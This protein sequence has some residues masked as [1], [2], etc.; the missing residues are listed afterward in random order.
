MVRNDIEKAVA[1]ALAE[2]GADDVSFSIDYPPANQAG[3]YASNAALAAAKSLKRPPREVATEL[4]EKLA[5]ANIPFVE[6]IEAAG[7]GFLN[8][9]LSRD[10]FA[11]TVTDIRAAGERWGGNDLLKGQ[12]IIAEYT[13][14]NPFKEFHIGHL[15]SNAI[16]ESIARLLAASG[17]EVR[18]ANYQG[19]VGLHVAKAIWGIKQLGGKVESAKQ[20]GE[21]YAKGAA[22]Y[23][24]DEQA[25]LEINVINKQVYERSDAEINALYDAG[26]KLSLERFEELY[27]TLGTKFDFYFFE[28]E[29]GPKGKELV[30]ANKGKVFEESEGAVVYRGEQDGLHTRVFLNKEGLPTYEAKELAL[31]RMKYEKFAYDRSIVITANEVNEYFKVVLAA[32]KRIE[33]ELAQKTEHVGHGFMRLTMGKMSSRKGNV[34]TGESLLEDMVVASKEKMAER[35]PADKE[36]IASQV[37]VA[38]IKYAILR[39]TAGKDIV[40]DEEKSLSLEGDSGP[41]LQYAHTRGCSILRKAKEEG[42]EASDERPAKL[43]HPEK[44]LARFPEAV[45]RAASTY[46]PHH[47]AQYLTELAGVFNSW[48]AVERVLDGSPEAPYKLALV[49]AVRVT[50]KNGLS[51]LGC[52]APEEM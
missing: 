42:V 27:A 34:I 32:L 15:M 9:H 39:Q 18:R 50:L 38:G 52:Q 35:A 29:A 43:S 25:K 20:L 44:L 28:S 31:P 23:E 5:A 6:K 26:R 46:E 12:K 7:A 19:D 47:I 21:A 51:L 30:L 2:M 14:P 45:A 24:D 33:P 1:K 16:G 10:F 48:Y 11:K 22:A 36:K 8:F 13:D 17:A 37:A 49:D 41:Y 40:F 4:A 3:D